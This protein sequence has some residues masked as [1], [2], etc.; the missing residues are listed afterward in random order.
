M[1]YSLFQVELPILLVQEY[2]ESSF[3]MGYHK[4]C[5]TWIPII[6]GILQCQTELSNALGKYAVAVMN[7]DSCWALNEREKREV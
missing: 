1:D 3:A 5:K 2:E 7:K 6:R 4:Y